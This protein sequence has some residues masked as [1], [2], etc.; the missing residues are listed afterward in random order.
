MVLMI[1]SSFGDGELIVFLSAKMQNLA[2]VAVTLVLFLVF[3]NSLTRLS[4]FG[5]LFVA[6]VRLF[7]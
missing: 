7:L 3:F 1:S 2:D 6:K 4:C 5:G